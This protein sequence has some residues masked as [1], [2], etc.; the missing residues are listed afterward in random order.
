MEKLNCTARGFLRS[1]RSQDQGSV[2][3]EIFMLIPMLVIVFV[4]TYTFF[5]MYR[6]KGGEQKANY[7]IADAMSRETGNITP[8]YMQSLHKLYQHMTYGAPEDTRI[9]ASVI[10]YNG[11][12]KD[13]YGNATKPENWQVIWAKQ[14]P[15]SVGE[16]IAPDDEAEVLKR[17]KDFIPTL[18]DGQSVIMMESYLRHEP[19]GNVPIS[20]PIFKTVS[21]T[22]PRFEA[23]ICWSDVSVDEETDRVCK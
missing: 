21:A 19:F 7:A 5:D 13:E 6:I 17:V 9:L 8:K 2:T 15:E 23:V 16:D 12:E 3:T 18:A 20:S 14:Y 4:S 10:K 11:P 22:S 1:F